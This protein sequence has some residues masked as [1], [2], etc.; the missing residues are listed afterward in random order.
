VANSTQLLALSAEVS[1]L[2]SRMDSSDVAAAAASAAAAA[3]SSRVQTAEAMLLS[4][5]NTVASHST[6][7]A[8]QQSST[9]GADATALSGTL[10][11]LLSTVTSHTTEI[12]SLQASLSEQGTLIN[13][14]TSLNSSNLAGAVSSLQVSV[15]S[16]AAELAAIS[17]L[18]GSLSSWQQLLA[19]ETT[20]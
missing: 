19:F 9:V 6:D 10:A 15:S 2:R 4:L 18:A 8:A 13:G 20:I 12:S 7:I 5:N 3:F 11:G 17:G 14:I 1:S 16:H